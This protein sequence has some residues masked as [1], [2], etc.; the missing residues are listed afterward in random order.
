[1][2]AVRPV[3]AARAV[4]AI[5]LRARPSPRMALRARMVLV[6][7]EPK[8]ETMVEDMEMEECEGEDGECGNPWG[9]DSDD[10]EDEGSSTIQADTLEQLCE[11]DPSA[12]EC[13]V[14]E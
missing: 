7:A 8:Q 4:P 11:A 5:G 2:T 13:R 3:V 12:D 6:R 9:D 14:Y 10:E 1:M